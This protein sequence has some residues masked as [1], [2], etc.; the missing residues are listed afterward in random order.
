[1]KP[2]GTTDP[3]QELAALCRPCADA[4]PLPAAAAAGEPQAVRCEDATESAL[5]RLRTVE[6]NQQLILAAVRQQELVEAAEKANEALRLQSEELRRSNEQL[7]GFNNAMVGRELRMIELKKEIDALCL[8]F[9]EPERYGYAG[10]VTAE[11]VS[12]EK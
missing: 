10:D 4:F 2:D 7:Q 12:H 3:A 6:M 8:K 11:S 1:M 5:L 9:G